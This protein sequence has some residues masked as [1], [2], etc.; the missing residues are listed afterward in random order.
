MAEM[1]TAASSTLA[2]FSTIVSASKTYSSVLITVVS[3]VKLPG[4]LIGWI[5]SLIPSRGEG[6]LLIRLL[7]IWQYCMVV[8]TLLWPASF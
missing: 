8:F 4:V 7:E 6:I 1:V 5:Y 2:P 3:K